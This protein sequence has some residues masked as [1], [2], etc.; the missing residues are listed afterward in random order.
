VAEEGEGEVESGTSA[1]GGHELVASLEVVVPLEGIHS[2][3]FVGV[4]EVIGLLYLSSAWYHRS[5]VGIVALDM[6]ASQST[7]LEEWDEIRCSV[8]A[9]RVR[10]QWNSCR[11][12]LLVPL[13]L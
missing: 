3:G 4:L 10:V 12:H 6:F 9:L 1:V 13:D 5:A 11:R 8:V 7:G 2:V